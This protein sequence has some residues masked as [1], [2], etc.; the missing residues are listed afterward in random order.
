MCG[1]ARAGGIDL[2]GRGPYA[3]T[4]LDWGGLRSRTPDDGLRFLGFLL[5]LTGVLFAL[6]ERGSRQGN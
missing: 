2:G 6:R 4:A 3:R 5:A 1:S